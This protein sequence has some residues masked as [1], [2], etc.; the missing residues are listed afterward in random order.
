MSVGPET[1]V[2]IGYSVFDAEGELVE[3]SILDAVFGYGELLPAV[4]QAVDGLTVGGRRRLELPPGQAYGERDPRAIVELDREDFPPDVALG[5]C[6]EAESASGGV[7]LLQVLEVLEDAVVVDTNHPLA[8]QTVRIELVVESVR[9]ATSDEIEQ[10]VLRL[11]RRQEEAPLAPEPGLVPPG[12]LLQGPSRRYESE[13]PTSRSS[14]PG[15]A[16]ERQHE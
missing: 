11:E 5:D 8:G 16:L 14:R 13:P 15:A 1:L 10:A 9:P 7:V 6:F 4:E 2:S 3:T 12:R